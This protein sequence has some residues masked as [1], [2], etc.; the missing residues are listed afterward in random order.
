[1]LRVAPE[2]VLAHD[3]VI[4]VMLQLVLSSTRSSGKRLVSSAGS[5]VHL[6]CRRGDEPSRVAGIERVRAAVAVAGPK[7][8]EGLLHA[9]LQG[10]TGTG[11]AGTAGTASGSTTGTGGTSAE[12]GP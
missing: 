9:L 1:M 2:G 6:L 5:L 7:L 8:V 4:L 12:S 10:G 3:R 11:T